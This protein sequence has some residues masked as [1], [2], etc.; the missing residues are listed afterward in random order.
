MTAIES[1]SI[2]PK[3]QNVVLMTAIESS[4]ILPKKEWEGNQR[5]YLS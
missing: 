2:L 1:S 5:K 3:K 4:S